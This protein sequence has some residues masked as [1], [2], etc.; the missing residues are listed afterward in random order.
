MKRIDASPEGIF[1]I[2]WSPDGKWLAYVAGG[3]EVRLANVETGEIRIIGPGL[4]PNITNDNKVVL[5]RN[6]EIVLVSG[7]GDKP[8]STQKDIVK[9]TP[10]CA[11]LLSPDSNFTVFGVMNVYDKVSQSQNAYPYRHFIAI[12]PVKGGKAILT[13]EQWYGGTAA[14]FPDGKR[15]AHFEFDSTS[16][17]QVHIVAADGRRE[18]TMAGLYPS[19]SPDG[20]RVAARPKGGGSLVVYSTKGSWTDEEIE[21]SVLRIPGGGRQRSSATPPI[22]LDNR[23][24]IVAESGHLW[25]MDT[26]RDKPEEIKKL[27]LPTERRKYSM[28]ASPSRELLALEVAVENAFELRA[29]SIF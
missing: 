15:F 26:K 13:T 10:K 19:V 23:H 6:G 1:D 27:P 18:G 25:R 11:P 24:V 21:T 4:C 16:G 3:E 28:I 29:V 20:S 5:E 8:I 7:D 17:P 22:W 9:D 2:A 14:W 12:A